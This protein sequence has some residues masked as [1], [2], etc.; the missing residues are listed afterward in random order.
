VVLR[1]LMVTLAF[2]PTA[3]GAGDDGW[4]GHTAQGF[5]IDAALS[6]TGALVERLHTRY[7]LTCSDD[8]SPVRP[9]L[10]SRRSGDTVVI[11]E[12]GRFATAGTFAG[13]LP[14]KGSGSVSYRVGGRV[15]AAR[16]AGTLRVDYTLDS[17]VTCT[18]KPV[19]FV[20]R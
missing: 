10:L 20:L 17:G 14:G 7:E 18:T 3:L 9:L 15:R 2:A 13:G 4:R 12:E 6:R 19:A 5:A 16:I 1:V 8:S 11:D